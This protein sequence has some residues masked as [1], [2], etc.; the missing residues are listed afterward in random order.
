MLRSRSIVTAAWRP[1][2][3]LS[4]I[5]MHRHGRTPRTL[6]TARMATKEM[7][8]G[9]VA[10]EFSA[11]PRPGKD[12]D[13]GKPKQEPGGQNPGPKR[14]PSPKPGGPGGIPPLPSKFNYLVSLL[15][16]SAGFYG[17]AA[18]VCGAIFHVNAFGLRTQGGRDG[19]KKLGKEGNK[20]ATRGR[21][22]EGPAL[23][24]CEG[25]PAP[26]GGR[27]GGAQPGR[28]S[29]LVLTKVSSERAYELWPLGRAKADCPPASME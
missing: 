3:T 23:E 5:P 21:D 24:A 18:V 19:K 13:G 9:H 14:G 28:S 2:S 10:G 25:D 15:V 29:E 6:V 16:A 27:L 8:D 17:T 12:A 7:L 1:R 22:V 20:K 4:T 26:G 11:E